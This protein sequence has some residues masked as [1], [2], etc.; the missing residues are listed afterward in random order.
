MSKENAAPPA[1][2]GGKMLLIVV[3]VCGLMALAAGVAVPYLL[4][5]APTKD[6][7]AKDE[8]SHGHGQTPK[9]AYVNF[10]DVVVNLNEDRL[11][12][13][14]RVKLLLVVDD[15]DE[16]V[17]T[18]LIGKNKPLLKNWL[19]SHLSDKSLLEVSG[20][21][22][23]NKLRREIWHEFNKELFPDGSEKILD[24]FFEEFVVQ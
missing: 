13:Y 20:A 12:R 23:V 7:H 2:S 11:T 6:S 15:H 18:D 8:S 19:I 5:H 3:G 10:G 4:M 14:L 16:K 9:R 22:G 24:I 1:K 21:P 17:M